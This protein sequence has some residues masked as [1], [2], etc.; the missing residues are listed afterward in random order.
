MSL[1][2]NDPNHPTNFSKPTRNKSYPSKI[3]FVDEPNVQK[4]TMQ[5]QQ[6]SSIDSQYILGTLIIRVVS[7]RALELPPGAG[8]S[9]SGGGG[10]VPGGAL[11]RQALSFASG[12]PVGCGCNPYASVRFNGTTQRTSEVFDSLDPVW[13]RQETMFMDVALPLTKVTHPDPTIAVGSGDDIIGGETDRIAAS[14]TGRGGG[15]S[16]SSVMINS[17]GGSSVVDDPYASYMKPDTTLTVAL[18]SN[19]EI[20]RAQKFP[21]K[22][23]M[24]GDS[25]DAFLGVAMV[26]L[27]SL[28]TGKVGTI[29]RWFP[30]RGGSNRSNNDHRRQKTPSI[31]NSCVRIVCEYEPSDGPPKAGDICRFTRYCHPRDLYPLEP[32][33]AFKVEQVHGDMV[34]LSYESQEGWVL[35]F[36]AHKNMLIC[37]ERH[38][39]AIESAQDELATLRER[40]VYSPLVSTVAKTADKVTEEG[41]IG[42]GEEIAKGGAFLLQRWFQGGLNTV[43]SDIQNVTNIDG[44]YNPNAGERL[45]LQDPS[46]SST[47]E[48]TS[49]PLQSDNAQKIGDDDKA[50]DEDDDEEALPNMPPC[51][52]TGFP[53]VEPVVAAD[54]HTYERV[55]I[56]RWLATSDKSPMTGSILIHKELVPNYGLMSSVREMAAREKE[57]RSKAS[58]SSNLKKPPP[59]PAPVECTDTSETAEESGGGN[60]DNDDDNDL[61]EEGGLKS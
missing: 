6:T 16:I 19:P 37:E 21:S 60:E 12:Q 40:L 22:A 56:Q 39:S 4:P 61:L 35:S 55:A 31:S 34:L 24:T 10:G 2:V 45:E 38:Q 27:T 59:T 41:I 32:G 50:D 3:A 1:D 20:G 54:G 58:A 51:P 36:Q 42:V 13:P 52:I 11:M 46:S 26:D 28:F 57:Q 48:D 29:D 9:G 18:F 53:M 25:D 8:G 14:S 5:Q 43:I 47:G 17:S 23:G 30:L 49:G 7:A 33:R 15:N 44:R